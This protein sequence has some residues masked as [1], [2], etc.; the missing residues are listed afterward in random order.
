[1]R[2]VAIALAS[3][4]AAA[5]GAPEAAGA[6][7]SN[8]VLATRAVGIVTT[9]RNDRIHDNVATGA[10]NKLHEGTTWHQHAFLN[11]TSA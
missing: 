5:A 2:A 1:M 8:L 7:D 3:S 4:A 10:G 11:S 6:A 9:K